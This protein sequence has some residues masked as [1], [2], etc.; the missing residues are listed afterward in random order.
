MLGI[1]VC[2]LTVYDDCHI[3]H[4]RLFIWFDTL[5][6]YLRR[7]GYQ[8]TY[9]RNITD[10]DDKI[11]KRAK[12][13]GLTHQALTAKVIEA[14]HQDA[15]LLNTLPPDIEPKVTEHILD[16]LAMI[17]VLIAKG[18]AYATPSGDVYYSVEKFKKYG[19]L[20]HQDLSCLCVGAR[21]ETNEEKKNPLDFVLWKAAKPDE[22]WW[23]SPWGNGRPGWHIECS[24]MAK[25]YLGNTFDIHGGGCDLQFPH[26]QNEVAQ[27]EA[28]NGAPLAHYWMHIGF[29]QNNQE[30][31]SKSLGNFFVLKDVLKKYHPE[32]LRYFMLCSHYRS[33]VNFSE[34]N[35]ENAE[36]A[37]RRFYMTLRGITKISS[38]KIDNED[39]FVK[40][41]HAAMADDF[42]TPMALAILFDLVRDINQFRDTKQL[43]QAEKLV[44]ILQDLGE[45]LGL[46]QENPATFLKFGANAQEIADLI[47]ERNA[48]RQNKNWQVADKIRETLTKMGI[49]LEDQPSGTNWFIENRKLYL[50]HQDSLT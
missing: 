24:A 37:L 41:F 28:A 48:A 3:G 36:G 50:I 1:Y 18:F 29:V 33:P 43:A 6:R 27:S 31:M 17:K 14:M 34:E 15:N 42:N 12:E 21:V 39:R 32:V 9:V 8:V 20:A 19:E 35:L 4:A 10:I 49:A 40:S 38:K 25:K 23:Q 30:K 45:S 22:P 2:G 44:A 7:V 46:F 26:H 13:L 11:I 5:V 16:I 47:A